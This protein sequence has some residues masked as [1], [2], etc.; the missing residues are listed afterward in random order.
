MLKIKNRQRR[1]EQIEVKNSAGK[2]IKKLD[3]ENLWPLVY[4]VCRICVARESCLVSVGRVAGVGGDNSGLSLC[5]VL[6]VVV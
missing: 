3:Y 6:S 1:R 2:R 5:C 4:W